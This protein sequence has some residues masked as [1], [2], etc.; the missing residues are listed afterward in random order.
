MRG[1]HVV[2]G[3]CGVCTSDAKE[4]ATSDAKEDAEYVHVVQIGGLGGLV[5]EDLVVWCSL[6]D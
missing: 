1:V 5:L 4:S 3:G 2:Q 6:E